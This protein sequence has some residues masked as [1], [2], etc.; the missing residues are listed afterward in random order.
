MSKAITK[1]Y[2]NGVQLNALIDTGSSDS[3]ISEEIVRRHRWHRFPSTTQIILASTSKSSSTNGHCFVTLRHKGTE[4]KKVKL[5]VLPDLCSDV[6]LGHDFLQRH[7]SVEIPFDGNE[8]PLLICNLA[9]STLP[10]RS[11]FSNLDPSCHPICTKSRRHS[12]EEEHFIQN[13]V[14][15]M[16]KEGIIEPSHSPWR[17][18]VLVVTNERQ[19]RRMVVDY[20]QTINRFTYLDAYPLPRVD[21]MVDKISKFEIFSTVDL[22]SAYH[23][24]PISESEREYTAFEACNNLYQFR[25]IPFGVTNGV[26]CFQRAMSDLVQRENLKGVFVYVDNITICGKTQQ[27]HDYNLQQFMNAAEKYGLTLNHEKGT[28]STKVI[29]LLGYEISNGSISPDPERFAALLNLP[30]QR[31]A[32]EQQRIVV[33]FAYYSQWFSVFR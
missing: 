18:Q 2:I 6:L 9:V 14:N 30:A 4:Y 3:Y 33:M 31:N 25:R 22:E 29:R 7:Q 12:N 21:D 13:E 23:Q 10:A 16:L 8:P 11:L 27:D 1:V 20:S 19:K 5:S 28:F 17:A 26:A 15:R 32:K 24:I